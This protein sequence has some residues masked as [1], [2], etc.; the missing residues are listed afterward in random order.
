M[1][2]YSG[3][4]FAFF[5]KVC[6]SSKTIPKHPALFNMILTKQEFIRIVWY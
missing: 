5:S 4:K 6:R 1:L 2:D 3:S